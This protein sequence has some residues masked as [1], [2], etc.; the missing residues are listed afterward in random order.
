MFGIGQPELGVIML[1]LFVVFIM[2]GFPITFTLM[3]LSVFFRFL[4][5][6]DLDIRPARSG[7]PYSVIT[8]DVLV[9]FQLFVP[10]GPV[11]EA[12][13]GSFSIDFGARSSR[14]AAGPLH[15]LACRWRRSRLS[16][17]SPPR[18]VSSAHSSTLM[19]ATRLPPA[20]C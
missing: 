15:G 17:F 10:M 18:P 20:T 14:S 12:R 2:F 8:N 3:A 4:A 11:V 9:S 7:A 6:G 1:G 13:G 5:M 16:R 19:A